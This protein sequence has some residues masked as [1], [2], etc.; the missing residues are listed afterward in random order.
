MSSGAP[1]PPLTLIHGDPPCSTHGCHS[2]VRVR[3]TEHQAAVT[4]HTVPRKDHL[5]SSGVHDSEP[6]AILGT[7][8][9]SDRT[10]PP[11]PLLH[12]INGS[13]SIGY[14]ATNT[15]LPACPPPRTPR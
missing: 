4:T 1:P 14:S 2:P 12:M 15:A 6:H 11:H 13:H 8:E 10:L 7:K 9:P 3:G 5:R